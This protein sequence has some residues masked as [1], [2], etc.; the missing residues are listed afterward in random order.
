MLKVF[1]VEDSVAVRKRMA[2]LVAAIDNVNVVGEADELKVA[3]ACIDS[4]AADVVII[5]LRLKHGSGL[6][7]LASLSC[8]DRP[9]V[10]IVLTNHSNT[11]FRDACMAAGAHYFFDKTT[12][13]AKALET[14]E[15]I[16]RARA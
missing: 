5:D 4:T 3:V 13:F 14:I 12:E 8:C 7:V 1:L 16:A 6:D 2:A 9:I 11:M 10:K 15:K